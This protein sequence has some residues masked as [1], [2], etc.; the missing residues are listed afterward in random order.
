MIAFFTTIGFGASV[1]LLQ[2]SAGRRC[3]ASFVLATIFAI[4]QNVVGTPDGDRLRAASAVRRARRLGHP[5]R[6]ARDGPR[7]RAAV[8]AGRASSARPRSPI[9]VAMAGIVAGGLVGGPVGHVPHRARD[10][11]PGARAASAAEP[12]RRS[13]ARD[14]DRHRRCLASTTTMGS[15]ARSLKNLVVILVAMWIGRLG[16]QRASPHSADAAGL[17]RRDAGRR[18]DPQP[19]R[20]DR[21]VRPVAPLHR[22]ASASWRSR[23]SSSWR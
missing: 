4:V 18:G 7:L 20:R 21:L 2:A 9:A 5:D 12:A 10:R 14:G 19:R 16:E 22:R 3:C 11:H 6:R 1:S 23:C 13:L 15:L 8:R 17:H